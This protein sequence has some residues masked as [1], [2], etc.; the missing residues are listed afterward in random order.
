LVAKKNYSRY[1]VPDAQKP[2][3]ISEIEAGN[4]LNPAV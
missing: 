2:K 1:A 3:G 4:K